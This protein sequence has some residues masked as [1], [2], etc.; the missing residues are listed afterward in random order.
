MGDIEAVHRLDM[1]IREQDGVLTRAQVL[2]CG[3]DS[4]FVRQK[5]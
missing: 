4:G 2:E 1:L 5:L 3:L